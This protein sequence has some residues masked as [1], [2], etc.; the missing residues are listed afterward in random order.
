MLEHA[1]ARETPRK[2]ARS[3]VNIHTAAVADVKHEE[4]GTSAYLG[5]FGAIVYACT[6][7]GMTHED[8]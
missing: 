4:L 7:S 2:S 5:M 6:S 3:S 1:L 8:Q